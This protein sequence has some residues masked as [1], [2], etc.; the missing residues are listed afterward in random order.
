[1]PMSVHERGAQASLFWRVFGLN[2]LVLLVAGLVLAVSPLTVSWPITLTQA[3]TLVAGIAVMLLINLALMRRTFAPLTRLASTMR[4]I[5]PLK[6]GQRVRLR[7]HDRELS[8]LVASF[9]EMLDRLETERRASAHREAKATDAEQR[10]IAGELHDEIGQRLTVL[11][12]MLANAQADAEPGITAKL[13]EAR[14]L[15]HEILDDLKDV[16]SRLRPAALDEL[17]IANALTALA[18]TIEQQTGIKI[19]RRLQDGNGEIPPIESLVVYRVAQEA[20]TNAVRHAP[21]SPIHL[22]LESDQICLRLRVS[23]RGPGLPDAS[24]GE[25]GRGL[26]WMAE[27]ALLIGG[28]LD[29]QS[30]ASGTTVTL[31]VPHTAGP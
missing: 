19:V 23:D 30:S 3:T 20:L 2:A 27:R 15:A 12:L 7:A 13:Q 1:M 9:N 21:G 31:T 16:V 29:L 6:P 24:D 8:D 11:L 10:R 14:D 17:G 22:E 5:D 25:R 4:E 28:T 26:T 18:T